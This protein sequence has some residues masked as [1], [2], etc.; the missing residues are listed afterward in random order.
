MVAFLHLGGSAL[1]SW[2]PLSAIGV[3]VWAGWIVRQVLGM[4]YRPAVHDH[5]PRTPSVVP[6]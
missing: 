6:V 4:R 2:L 1:P 5:R 3:L